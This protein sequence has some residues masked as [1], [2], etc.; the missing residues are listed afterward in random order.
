MKTRINRYT[1]SAFALLL[2]CCMLMSCVL[3]SGAAQVGSEGVGDNNVTFYI[4]PSDLW[5][6]YAS[7]TIKA[8]ANI[9]DNNTWRSFDFTDT[10]KTI[11][12]KAVYKVTITEKYGGVDQL[13][14]QKYQGT[15]WKDQKVPYSSWTTSSTF[16]GKIYDGSSWSSLPSYDT[17]KIKGITG[18]WNSTGEINMVFDSNNNYYY[19]FDGDGYDKYYRLRYGLYY[20]A[21]TADFN[22]ETDGEYAPY[23]G[24]S[25]NK[26]YGLNQGD[27]KAFKL[28]TTTNYSYRIYFD[29]NSKKTWFTKTER[30]HS[31][32]VK[33]QLGSNTA[34]SV[35]TATV[36]NVTGVNITA[37]ETVTSGS[38][39]YTFDHWV[40]SGGTVSISN[41]QNGTYTNKTSGT[42]YST[43]N[44]YVK[45]AADNAVLTAVYVL[46]LPTLSAPTNVK[47]N[48]SA[49]NCNVTATTVGAKVNLT[50]SSVTGAGSYKIF[51]GDS[52]VTTV[53][54]TSYSIE[55]AA[56]S[57]GKYT[58]VAVPSNT[59]QYS[60]SVK[61]SGYTLTVSKKKLTN[62]TVTVSPTAIAL[63]QST[64]LTAT[65]A[66]S[67]VTAGQY[68]LYYYESSLSATDTYKLTSGTAK[69]ITP[70]TAGAHT[71]K[72]EAYPVGG[73]NNDYYTTSDAASASTVT[74]YAPSWY[75]VGDLVD[76]TNDK[77]STNLTS[78]PVDEFVSA[79]VFRRTVTYASGGT[80]DK[81]YF[82]LNNGTNQY[83]VTE[84][85]DTDMATHTTSLTAVTASAATTSGAMYVTGQGTY[86]IYVDQA[87]G[88][89]PKVWVEKT[90]P[91]KYTTI[92]YVNKDS[93]ATNMYVWKDAN[94]AVSAW[95]GE[96][97]TTTEETVN[98]I[99]YYKYTF[100]SYWDHFDI[101]V[102]KGNGNNQSADLTNI[103]AS[104][105]YYVI[106]DGGA[107][108][109]ASI[110]ETAPVIQLGYKVQNSNN[111]THVDFASR[112]V[113][114]TLAANTTY[115]FWLKSANSHLND[116]NAGTM[117][118]A[119]CTSWHFPVSNSNTKIQA[120]LAG[121][122]TFTYTVTNGG[123]YVSVTYPPEPK[124]NVTV[125]QGDHGT[126]KVN[127]SS[128]TTGGTIQ[129]G[130]LTTATVQ[131]VAASGY[132]F[133]GWTTTGG[134]AAVSGYTTSS[135][136]IT[137][138]ASAVGT[139]TANYAE[140]SYTLTLASGGN[141]SITAPSSKTLTVHPF[142]ATS[143]S[144]V[145][146]SPDNG[147]EFNGWTAGTGVTL[148]GGSTT[149]P[150]AGTV[151]ATQNATLTANF[152]KVSYSLTGETSL[153]G[154]VGNYGT[155]KFYSDA[156]CT[157][158]ITTAQ[159]GNTVYA[160][161]R[162]TGY[163][164]VNF[165]L[166]GTGASSGT[167]TDNVFQFTMGYANATVTAN[168]RQQASVT[169]YVD[170]HDNDMTGKNVEVAIV[171]NGGGTTV[172]KDGNGNDCK[173]NLT[174]Q[175][176]SAVYAATI[177]TPLTQ[178]ET[179]YSD[180]Y[181]KVTFNGSSYTKNLPGEKVAALVSSGEMWLEAKNESS[182]ALTFTYDN[183]SASVVA[184]GYRRIYLAKPYSWE[185]D[186][187]D[188]ETIG[189]Y[190]WGNYLDIGWNN[191][192]K[193]H[194]LGYDSTGKNGYHYYYA[195]IPKALASNGATVVTDGTGNKVSN[196]I[197]QGWGANQS[198]G[199]YNKAQTGNIENIADDAN[200]FVLS[201]DGNSYVGTKN[202]EDAIIPNYSRYVSAVSLN[203]TETTVA[204]IKPNYTGKHISYTTNNSSVVTVDDD[205]NLTPVGRGTTTVTVKIYG[206]LGYLI[207]SAH[208]DTNHKDYLQYT[209]SVTVKDPTQFEGFEIMS[210]ESKTY[211]VNIPA[212]SNNQPG[213]FDMNNIVMTVEGLQGV[214]SSTNSA[215]I[216]QTSTTSSDVG[217]VCTAF[218]VQYAKA[219]S[220]FTGYGN[221]NVIGKIVTKS[222]A[223]S[224]GARYG[225]DHWERDGVEV[226]YTTSRAVENSV[227]TATTAAI[228][229]DDTKTTYSA[230]F[231][232][233]SYVDVTFTFTY[234]EY[235]PKKVDSEGNV[236]A[237]NEDGMIQYPYDATWAGGEDTSNANFGASHTQK[238]V[239]VQ[240]YEVRNKTA[241]TVAP[242][243]LVAPALIAIG[244][245]PDNNYY[246]YSIAADNITISGTSTYTANA[247]VSMA[248]SVKHYSVYL[249]GN[250]VGSN[251]TYQEYAEPS[252]DTVSKW[253]AD[254][255]S[256]GPLLATGTSYK[257][258]VKGN[259]NLVTVSGSLDDSD[260]NRSEVGFSHYE[261]THRE[262]QVENEQ[263]K[264]VE[265]VLQNFYIADFFDKEKV[266]DLS[267]NDGTKGDDP[268]FV[269]GGVVYYSVTN[270]TPFANAV[271]SGYVGNDGTINANAIKEML[272]SNIEAQYAKDG[273]AGTVGEDEA[274]KIAYGTEIAAKKN[275]EGGFNTGIIYRYLPLNQYKRDGNGNLAADTEGNY[276]YDVNSNTFRYSNSLQSYQYVYASG[277]ENKATNDG[278]NMRLYSYYVYSYVAY[279]KDTNLPETH[280]EIVLSD[281]YSDAS[282][283]WAGNSNN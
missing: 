76:S 186:E 191:G 115:E 254:S 4:Y 237:D 21:Y 81:H 17:A 5:S 221:I 279:N 270:G 131:A 252:V 63:G 206:S 232:A 75:L 276:T 170:M 47:L 7:Y 228:P 175:G 94:N 82:R 137:I 241:S 236:V 43:R 30:T 150:S 127:G 176:N 146:V 243:D 141:G 245:M 266:M 129:I 66:N 246:N 269:G 85:T 210:L 32:A 255:S 128:F 213:Y 231:V 260:F 262:K 154:T 267:R 40:I 107:N 39:S 51:K 195:D 57:T 192:I 112:S 48:G 188:W 61:S 216:T 224:G 225:H 28:P 52:L 67:G 74:V 248:H 126:V 9:G 3:Q 88:G 174:Q 167:T 159:I 120:D 100:E 116:E 194:Y 153:N 164:V 70:A 22:L 226:Q 92:V 239:T 118:R 227:E 64:N 183:R 11:N 238:T 198:A 83:T 282:T 89:S 242:S 177:N 144:G 265:Y 189:I 222:I 261:I 155:V 31:V 173:A 119:N 139:I 250:L 203:K 165:T 257:F 264:N 26:K 181:I 281:Q 277:N 114:V 27:G 79:N 217:I 283:Y 158:E 105:T 44:I 208:E 73:A 143:L 49:A 193:M 56:S 218:T 251:Y 99:T 133:T 273:I 274:M 1:K 219:N 62:P 152:T 55:K 8:N 38:N 10:G 68:H 132:H 169:Y 253:Y 12:G 196:L 171:T 104:K 15:T 77:W 199:T 134:V 263:P 197:F 29:V 212:I 280:Y 275:V 33:Q 98:D 204:T 111:P 58:V 202:N 16:S 59:S 140:D 60:E 65:D 18:D 41:S 157:N 108:T 109:T 234:W 80:N 151:K 229:F 113:S 249:N 90:E 148:T 125:N 46:N 54:T 69:S 168:V 136:P 200:F 211:T 271:S 101:V 35:S 215:I 36:G 34:T 20:E 214:S 6:D 138:S 240:N 71:Y 201:K 96:D 259:T 25:D 162:S 142:T 247:A 103:A 2:A 13:Q 220:M 149:N 123:I 223:R 117:T 256:S 207:P 135:N 230:I 178:T 180:L 87:T 53:T 97:I 102:N 84:G 19:A 23:D 45:T 209:V 121:T 156:A 122:Y 272:K 106:W 163:S 185:S 187:P 147:Y 278:K 172:A 37:N 190:H 72:V 50:W 145:T 93:V 14:I 160:K 244:V 86:T 110:S 184:N 130:S 91:Q 179:S 161:F 235:K 205:G 268:T 182:T 42:T 24:T 233:Y 124:Y 258:R 166:V 78:Y 95:P